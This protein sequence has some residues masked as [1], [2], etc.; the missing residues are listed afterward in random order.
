MGSLIDAYNASACYMHKISV[1]MALSFKKELM[2]Q[3]ST[4]EGKALKLSQT[5]FI[6][7]K[8]DWLS[9][10][11]LVF[12]EF[13]RKI[14]HKIFVHP[15]QIFKADILLLCV[16]NYH[17]YVH[18]SVY[19]TYIQFYIAMP[20]ILHKYRHILTTNSKYLS[21]HHGTQTLHKNVPVS[22]RMWISEDT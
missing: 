12:K 22:A 17:M 14:H 1:T 2:I 18:I 4:D 9:V 11:V 20:C 13:T 3:L 8:C 7:R 5:Q 19:I 10:E 6:I 15:Y 21:D 16:V